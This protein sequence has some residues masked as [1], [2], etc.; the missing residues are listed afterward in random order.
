VTEI[1]EHNRRILDQVRI[2]RDEL[3]ESILGV[4]SALSAP[5]HERI[6]EWSRRVRGMR[7]GIRIKR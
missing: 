6:P 2:H 3:Y 5:A 4:E 1:Q 7:F